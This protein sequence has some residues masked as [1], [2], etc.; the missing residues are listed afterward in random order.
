[1]ALAFQ[2]YTLQFLFVI[3]LLFDSVNLRGVYN[4]FIVWIGKQSMFE[5]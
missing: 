4:K 5:L 2:K 3:N 1:M